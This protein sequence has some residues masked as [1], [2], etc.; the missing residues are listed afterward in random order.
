MAQGAWSAESTVW[1]GNSNLWSNDTYADSVALAMVSNMPHRHLSYWSNYS[2]AWNSFAAQTEEWGYIPSIAVPRTATLAANTSMS[3]L[4]GFSLVAEA[5][6]A[7]SA[8]QTSAANAVYPSAITLAVTD[9]ISSI[10]NKLYV[11]SITFANT[12]NI[13]L[14]GTTTWDLETATWTSTTGIWG[15]TPTVTLSV[16]ADITQVMLNSLNAEDI[17]K[18]AS[19]LM[20]TDLGVS[21]TVTVAIPVSGTLANEQDMKF[22]INFEELA[23]LAATSGISSD[24]SFLWNDIA[25]DTGS[26]WT[27]VSDPDE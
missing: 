8:G 22:N 19:A 15:Y 17:E 9:D 2:G 3:T 16:A 6:L 7:L 14:P 25:E 26:T 4:G 24:N 20:P 21:A 5:V 12:L 10:G 27:K 11:E 1:S 13:P 23:T 18:I